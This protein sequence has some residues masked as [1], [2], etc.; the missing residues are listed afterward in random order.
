MWFQSSAR[1]YQYAAGQRRF[2]LVVLC[3]A[4][5]II[6]GGLWFCQRLPTWP[7][8]L[9]IVGP[10]L[11]VAVVEWSWRNSRFCKRCGVRTKSPR[12][13]AAFVW[14]PACHSLSDPARITVDPVGQFDITSAAYPGHVDPVLRF[15]DFVTLWAITDHVREIR[16]EPEQHA[17][18]IRFVIQ[19]QVYEVMPPPSWA[20]FPVAQ[21]VKAIAGLEIATCDR[22]QEGHIDVVSGSH[23]VATNVIVEPTEFGQKVTLR[24]LTEYWL[25]ASGDK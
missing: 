1:G 23:H 3:F 13:L 19:E 15:L 17:F 24:F 10:M 9:G 20:A 16:F 12:A 11:L 4:A 7:T 22:R 14:C 18:E 6:S 5:A 25:P 8:M 21:T 2:L